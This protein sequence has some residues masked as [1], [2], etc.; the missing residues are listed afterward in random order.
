MQNTVQDPEPEARGDRRHD[1]QL[2]V[3]PVS[4]REPPERHVRPRDDDGEG[5]VRDQ[6][7][8][9]RVPPQEPQRGRQPG[10]EAAVQQPGHARLHHQACATRSA[11]S[12]SWHAP[13][14]KEVRPG[15]FH[16]IGLA[17]HAC[18]HGAGGNP[19]TGQ[20]IINTDGS[21]QAVS[22]G[23]DIGSGQRTKMMMI[24]AEALGVPLQHGHDHAVRRHRQHHRHRWH[25]G[26]RMTNTGGRGM[27]EAASDARNQVLDCGAHASSSIDGREGP[28]SALTVSRRRHRDQRRR[29]LPQD[30]R[31]QEA[32]ARRRSSSSRR[33]SIIGSPTTCSPRSWERTAWAAHAAEVEVDTRHRHG[34]GHTLRGGARRGQGVQP[35]LAPSSRSK[36]AW[37]WRSARCFTEELLIDKATGLPLNPNMLDYRPLSIKDAPQARGDH[38]REAQGVR[39]VRRPRHRRAA[40]GSAGAGRSSTPSTTRSACG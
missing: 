23:T 26:S 2:Q 5:G 31:D 15:V 38:R 37:S 30:R 3:G 6:H 10:H 4:L 36:A 28:P 1:Q 18:S 14:A 27:Y 12:R 13:K 34:Q 20:V 29:R 39:R 24:A 17:A 25:H 22:G 8:P 40:H 19:A 33:T 11:G 7:G 32:H 9:G 21:V 16:G 35:V